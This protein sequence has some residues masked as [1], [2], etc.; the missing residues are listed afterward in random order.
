[1]GSLLRFVKEIL[2]IFELRVF[3]SLQNRED[4]D[5]RINSKL[6]TGIS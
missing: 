5:T 1:M 6:V 3:P 4:K 2:F